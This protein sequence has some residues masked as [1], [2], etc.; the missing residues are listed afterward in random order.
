MLDLVVG[1]LEAVQAAEVGQ[2]SDE[3]A[4]DVHVSCP[5]FSDVESQQGGELV[6]VEGEDGCRD[7][8]IFDLLRPRDG[9][10]REE[11]GGGIS[12]RAGLK[13]Q[14]PKT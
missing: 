3:I 2:L 12:T 1:Q 14:H 9:G 10:D 11:Q 8:E 7:G 5:K 6:V 4:G 13:S